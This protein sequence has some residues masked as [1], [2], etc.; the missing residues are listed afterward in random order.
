MGG[1]GSGR[2]AGLGL[3]VNKTSEMHS[4]DLAWLRRRRLFNVGRWTTL[5]WSSGGRPTGSI[6][7]EV[8]LDAVR[9]VY[10]HQSPGSEDWATV[11]ERVPLIE[12]A[13]RFGGRRQWFL[14]LSCNC[15]CRI[16]YGGAR[17]R[18]RRC[19]DLKYATQ[20]EPDFGRAATRALKIR[21]RLGCTGGIDDPFPEKPK[22][23][24]WATYTRLKAEEQR[25]QQAWA[26]GIVGRFRMGGED[27]SQ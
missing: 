2:Q 17:F 11:D 15:R 18:C 3:M 6:R 5:R 9:L 21:E 20:Y 23:M 22:G 13:A 4:I 7:L 12:T 14:C 19:L 1:R 26:M 8:H 25:L 10:R 27:G 24:H 16:L